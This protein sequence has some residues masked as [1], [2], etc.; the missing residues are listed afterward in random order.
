MLEGWSRPPERQN[1]WLLSYQKRRSRRKR[2][3]TAPTEEQNQISCFCKNEPLSSSHGG[4]TIWRIYVMQE[5]M[6]AAFHFLPGIWLW[7]HLKQKLFVA[8]FCK[9]KRLSQSE[10][11]VHCVFSS[12]NVTAGWGAG[13]IPFLSIPSFDR[14]VEN[15]ACQGKQTDL[16]SIKYDFMTPLFDLPSVLPRMIII[17]VVTELI[18]SKTEINKPFD[19]D[20]ESGSLD[21]VLIQTSVVLRV[22]VVFFERNSS[23]QK[24]KTKNNNLAVRCVDLGCIYGGHVCTVWQ[25]S[26]PYIREV[27]Q[28]VL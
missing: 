17:L 27:F 6:L 20:C 4:K 28:S 13:K 10:F 1:V 7:C 21:T 16:C 26:S 23:G 15:W 14:Y 19:W 2:N 18:P 9:I 5:W 24:N 11:G 12:V 8:A 22:S 25:M 3:F